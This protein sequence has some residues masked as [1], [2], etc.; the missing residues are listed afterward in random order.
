MKT[1]STTAAV[2]T[3]A[4][5]KLGLEG[6]K[7]ICDSLYECLTNKREAILS[8]LYTAPP[9]CVYEAAFKTGA[10]VDRVQV[11]GNELVV[12]N[13]LTD[14]FPVD[15]ELI[16]AYAIIVNQPAQLRINYNDR[17]QYDC[18]YSLTQQPSGEPLAQ[19][20][21]NPYDTNY[22]FIYLNKGDVLYPSLNGETVAHRFSWTSS[23]SHCRARQWTSIESDKVDLTIV[24]AANKHSLSQG[25]I[26]NFKAFPDSCIN[27]PSCRKVD[28]SGVYQNLAEYTKRAESAHQY[29]RECIMGANPLCSY[30]FDY[31][32]N[33]KLNDTCH[34][35]SQT[36]ASGGS[37]YAFRVPSPLPEFDDGDWIVSRTIKSGKFNIAMEDW[38]DYGR[39]QWKIFSVNATQGCY[40]L[41]E[42]IEDGKKKNVGCMLGQQEHGLVCDYC[43]GTSNIETTLYITCDGDEYGC[44]N[45]PIEMGAALKNAK[46]H[47]VV[48]GIHIA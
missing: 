44:L 18:Y 30:E 21:R 7:V 35:V 14:I 5:A 10:R 29:L 20:M 24:Y 34:D 32:F 31:Y 8:C 37:Q 16:S 22:G 23:S 17:N 6:D 48:R 46:F 12:E 45:S 33:G 1:L 9:G 2:L 15:E 47:F 11:K 40:N 39:N 42:S 19:R 4:T 43:M 36:K 27:V 26:S 41:L 3:F 38:L 28:S 13:F 25:V